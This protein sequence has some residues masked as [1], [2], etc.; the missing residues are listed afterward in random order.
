MHPVVAFKAVFLNLFLF[1]FLLRL[2]ISTPT[3]I[4]PPFCCLYVILK[5]TKLYP[6]AISINMGDMGDS[7][8]SEQTGFGD[9]NWEAVKVEK[10]EKA[11]VKWAVEEADEAETRESQVRSH[12][13]SNVGSMISRLLT[14]TTR[15]LLKNLLVA[16]SSKVLGTPTTLLPRLGSSRR[17][18]LPS[19]SASRSNTLLSTDQLM[20]R[21]RS[22]CSRW[23]TPCPIRSFPTRLS[24]LI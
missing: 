11:E 23:H 22:W 19:L 4:L 18:P 12:N 3:K 24:L 20:S 15:S 21:P 17:S 2:Y 6:W 8:H 10:V 9:A 7:I 5:T 1:V 13:L 14:H 16:M